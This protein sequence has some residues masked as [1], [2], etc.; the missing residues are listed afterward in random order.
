MIATML[1]DM[2]LL[3][4]DVERWELSRFATDYLSDDLD[5][6]DWRDVWMDTWEIRLWTGRPVRYQ[7]PPPGFVGTVAWD[8]TWGGRGTPP[9]DTCTVIADFGRFREVEVALGV[10]ARL[11]PARDADGYA[12]DV[13][14]RLRRVPEPPLRALWERQAADG[15]VTALACRSHRQ[16]HVSMPAGRAFFE[17]GA[18]LAGA[19][20]QVCRSLGGTLQ[21]RERAG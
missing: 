6:D 18:K 1:A 16:L 15:P 2:G 21:W 7:P 5:S 12:V 4:V 14:R 20:E 10:F 9:A 8:E 13:R 17:G 3:Q 19:V 11:A